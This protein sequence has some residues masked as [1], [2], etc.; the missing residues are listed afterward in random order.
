MW[1]YWPCTYIHVPLTVNAR[2]NCIVS[3]CECVQ[4][5][6][7]AL[8]FSAGVTNTFTLLMNM[9]HSVCVNTFNIGD[10][11]LALMFSAAQTQSTMYMCRGFP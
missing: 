5:K 1:Q 8:T 3:A 10:E 9:S 6:P 2:Y 11:Y 7:L 4:S